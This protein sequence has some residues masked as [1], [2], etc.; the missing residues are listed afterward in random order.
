MPKTIDELE[1]EARAWYR[2]RPKSVQKRILEFPPGELFLMKRTGHVCRIYAYTTSDDDARCDECQVLI[3]QED[4]GGRLHEDRRVFGVEFTNL[5]PLPDGFEP[6]GDRS[7]EEIEKTDP[8]F[9]TK[10]R[11]MLRDATN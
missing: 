11:Q 5:V 6:P 1:P 4:N 8:E 10:V 3:L 2:A 7:L 9:A